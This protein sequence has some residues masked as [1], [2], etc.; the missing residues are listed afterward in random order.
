M[1]IVWG[2]VLVRMSNPASTSGMATCSARFQPGC[3]G[4]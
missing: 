2:G 4:L 3:R 1:A